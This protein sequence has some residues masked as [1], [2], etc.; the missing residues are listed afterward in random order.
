MIWQKVLVSLV[1]YVLMPV[2]FLSSFALAQTREAT[3]GTIA[4]LR[5]G[6]RELR[7]LEGA[8]KEG[9]LV[10]YSSTTA[11]DSLALVR[12]FEGMYPFLRVQHLRSSSEKMLTRILT[13]SRAG[14]FK[15]DVLALPEIELNILFRRNLLS[16]YLSPEQESYP[17]E[18]K[19]PRG[20]WTGMYISAWVLAYNTKLV[21]SQVAP[22]SYAD[23]L[24]PKW[25]GGIALDEE[26]YSW[27]VTSLRYLER[28]DGRE[29]A[30]DY[31]KRLARQEIQWRK[32][33]SLIGQLMAAGEFP[34]AAE[35]QVHTVERLKAQGAPLEWVPLEGVIPIH[36]VGVAITSGGTNTHASALFYDFILSRA[37]MEIIRDRRRVPTR[38]DVTVPYLKPY[39]LLPFDSQVM[40]DFDR[41]VALFRDIFKPG[42]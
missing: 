27:F 13:E 14:S 8:R 35:L 12:K 25:K 1:S 3:L 5:G 4:K 26:P 2:G 31:F 6:E 21:S 29:A 42:Q 34:L 19:D 11:E 23:L 22:R 33:H 30:L 36:K 39:R 17:P 10:W 37:G 28:R 32:G 40:D 16:S 15:A 20:H 41:Y 38:P 9:S 24:L 7:L 18:M